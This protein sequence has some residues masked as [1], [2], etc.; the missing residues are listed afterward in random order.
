MKDT[1]VRQLP[2]LS[3]CCCC[4][5]CCLTHPHWWW[6]KASEGRAHRPRRT[7]IRWPSPII[8]RRGSHASTRTA[9]ATPFIVWRRPSH[10][11][12]ALEPATAVCV[13]T[14]LKLRSLSGGIFV[15][16]GEKKRP[17]QAAPPRKEQ[18]DSPLRGLICS[19][20]CRRYAFLG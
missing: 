11:A 4:C 1:M 2:C 6:S 18:I 15:M 5:C 10:A 20:L 17:A 3:S 14:P 19:D 8:H 12:A 9:P 13:L 16:V 7:S